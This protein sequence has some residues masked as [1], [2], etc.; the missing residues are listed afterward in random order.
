MLAGDLDLEFARA[1]E[2]LL[3]RPA[4]LEGIEAFETAARLARDL[5]PGA[6][7]TVSDRYQE[8]DLTRAGRTALQTAAM[9]G[10]DVRLLIPNRKIWADVIENIR[11]AAAGRTDTDQTSF[12]DLSGG[13]QLL[14]DDERQLTYYNISLG[15]NV[16]PGEV[17]IGS[18]YA[19]NSALYLIGGVGNTDFGGDNHF[20]VNVGAGY[21]LPE[22][23]RL[24]DQLVARAKKQR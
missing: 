18:G 22:P 13:A 14:T 16:F 15:W 3:A 9:S 21:R 10:I 5:R 19:F 2:A 24:A 12:E 11:R 8:V 7:Y 4:T 17:F 6:D 20:T 1:V 23:T